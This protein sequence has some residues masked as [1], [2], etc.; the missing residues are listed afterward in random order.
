MVQIHFPNLTTGG[1][2]WGSKLN[3]SLVKVSYNFFH[4]H[5]VPELFT[6]LFLTEM[7]IPFLLLFFSALPDQEISKHSVPILSIGYAVT[8]CSHFSRTTGNKHAISNYHCFSCNCCSWYTK[9]TKKIFC[10]GK[11]FIW[12]FGL[13]TYFKEKSTNFFFSETNFTSFLTR[14]LTRF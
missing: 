5:Y 8:I 2:I 6:L 1:L 13:P 7:L 10:S 9:I 11:H 3:W 12:Y 14:T 4:E